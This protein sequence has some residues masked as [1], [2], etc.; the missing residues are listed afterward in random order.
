MTEKQFK[1][2]KIAQ[3]CTINDYATLYAAIKEKSP[4][5]PEKALIPPEKYFYSNVSHREYLSRW[6][7]G[8]ILFLLKQ[9]GIICKK[10]KTTGIR[11]DNREIITDVLGRQRVIGSEEWV[12]DTRGAIKGEPDVQAI[13]Q[14]RAVYFEVKIK[15]DRL[16]KDQKQFIDQSGATVFIIKTVSDFLKAMQE[17]RL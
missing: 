16:S 7:E 6:M 15:A 5:M 9:R 1:R 10:V 2:L 4:N 12:Q 8:V 13:I 11:V 14:G 3:I 17:L